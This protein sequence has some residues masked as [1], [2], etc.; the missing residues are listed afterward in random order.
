LCQLGLTADNLAYELRVAPPINA[1]G[2]TTQ[3]FDD[4]LAAFDRLAAIERALVAE[5]W[6]LESFESEKVLRT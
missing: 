6:S 4:A 5:G 3:L 1:A 2:F